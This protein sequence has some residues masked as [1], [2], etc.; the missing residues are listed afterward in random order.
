MERGTVDIYEAQASR[1]IESRAA[2]R[3]VDAAARLASLAL[4][5]LAV[6][7][8]GCGPGGHFPVLGPRVVGVDAARAL[9]EHARRAEVPGAS[10]VQ[11]DLMALPFRGQAFG[12]AWARMSYHHVPRAAL[13]LALA[14]LHLA[15][16]VGAPLALVSQCGDDEGAT[17]PDD[18]FP[19]RYF[20]CWRPGPLADVLVGAG[21]DVQSCAQDGDEVVAWAV[22]A[23][24]L[25]DTVAPGMRLLVCGLNPSEYAADAGAGF[26]RRTNRFWPA[27]VAAGLVAPEHAWSPL[28]L[29]AHHSIGMTDL[30]KRASVASAALSVDEYRAGA[31]RVRRLV[32]WLRP[33][34]VCFVGLEGWRAAVDRRAQAGW[35]PDGFG[36]APAYVMPSTSGRVPG[37]IDAAAAH[38]RTAA[39][40]PPPS[41]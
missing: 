11:A 23:R 41:P 33:S 28:S 40:P 31:D 36:G 8:V 37:G 15:L 16:A 6:V 35:Q 20:A 5:G 32:S 2:P 14:H 12:G 34:A 10:V 4:P 19:G 9:L 24:S 22:R 25:P 7:D 17:G 38:L 3:R 1:W 39:T 30:V 21:F 18:E 29:L 13:P 26:A 27:L